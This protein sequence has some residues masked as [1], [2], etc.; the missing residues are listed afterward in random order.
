MERATIVFTR[1]R[2]HLGSKRKKNPKERLNSATSLDICS[3]YSCK[4]LFSWHEATFRLLWKKKTLKKS[5]LLSKCTLFEDCS[6]LWLEG[7]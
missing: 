2:S 1:I 4:Y 6:G 3:K 7:S 5:H